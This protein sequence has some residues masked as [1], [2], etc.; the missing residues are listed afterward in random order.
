MEK[1]FKFLLTFNNFLNY[2]IKLK[3]LKGKTEK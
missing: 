3:S 2:N 1:S